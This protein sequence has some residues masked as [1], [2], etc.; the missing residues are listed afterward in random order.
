M[1]DNILTFVILIHN[2][3]THTYTYLFN[4]DNFIQHVCFLPIFV[5]ILLQGKYL[6][7][8]MHS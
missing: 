7:A 2:I 5:F 1:N 3:Y 8:V 6:H 4:V